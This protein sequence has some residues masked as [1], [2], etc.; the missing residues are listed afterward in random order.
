MEFVSDGV[1][2]TNRQFGGVNQTQGQLPDPDAVSEVRVETT[3][4]GAQ[5]ATPGVAVITT[6]SGTNAFHGS[7]FETA[8]NNAVGIAKNRNNLASFAAPHLVRNEF[9]ASAGGPII[10]PH[11]YN[12]KSK[13]F[14]FVAYERYSLSQAASELVAVPTQA[15]RN[16]DFSGLTNSAG[17]KLQLYDPATTHSDPNCNGTGKANPYCRAPFGNGILGSPVNNQIP[18]SRLSPTAK[19]LFD[20]TPLPSDPGNP[21]Q[22]GSNLSTINP[23]YTVIPNFSVR[24]DHYFNENNRAY[25]RFTGIQQT[26][27]NLRNNPSS[28]AS[29]AADG[30][31]ANA[32]G[33]ALNPTTTYAGAL[34]YRQPAMVFTA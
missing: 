14:W 31:P 24:V 9:G 18:L 28:P 20:I 8:R 32:N 33:L 5:Y 15:F 2:L 25:V 29:L 21:I 22:A 34:G 13:T 1:P 10:I 26:N 30:L 7:L 16:G 27:N 11:V 23:T 19:I 12:G 4:V 6:R 17:V 3:D